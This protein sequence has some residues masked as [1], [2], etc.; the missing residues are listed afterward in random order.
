M[1]RIWTAE[2]DEIIRRDRANR[3]PTPNTAAKLN[4]PVPATYNRALKLKAH[5]QVHQPWP[6]E[7]EARLKLAMTTTN[8]P[9]TDSVLA[10]L[11]G[12]PIGSIRWKLENIGLIGM[13]LHIGRPRKTPRLL[14]PK[15]KA[16]REL[17]AAARE[18][19]QAAKAERKNARRLKKQA[20]EAAK[21]QR[22]QLRLDARLARQ[23]EVYAA[24]QEAK[25]KREANALATTT[26][27]K[28]PKPA[29]AKRQAPAA[30]RQPTARVPKVRI[31]ASLPKPERP[32]VPLQRLG[33]K[34]DRPLQAR[35]QN[36]NQPI[37]A[38]PL[39]RLALFREAAKR[40]SAAKPGRV[41]A[42][43]AEARLMSMMLRS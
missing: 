11:F 28:E 38:M 21:A 3:V 18:A 33:P 19:A 10:A 24:R 22:A 6:E 29:R 39:D 16:D 20:T 15:A 26:K 4:R 8:P 17:R 7:D 34:T 30:A 1:N 14:T 31:V 2:E 32:G 37:P 12:R 43:E 27:V 9:P 5:V 23:A 13:R 35:P 41:N 36:A 42:A 25:A 40:V